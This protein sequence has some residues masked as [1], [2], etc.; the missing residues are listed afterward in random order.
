MRVLGQQRLGVQEAGRGQPR[1]EKGLGSLKGV[2]VEREGVPRPLAQ[3]G[4]HA[5]ISG[6]GIMWIP[7][8]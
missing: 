2:V 3:L 7:Q 1:E 6:T 5:V 8:Y 4:R